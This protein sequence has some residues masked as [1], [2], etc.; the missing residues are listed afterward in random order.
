MKRSKVKPT[1]LRE[2]LT[3]PPVSLEISTFLLRDLANANYV[4]FLSVFYVN[5]FWV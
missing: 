4:E 5:R 2:R 3:E 1:P